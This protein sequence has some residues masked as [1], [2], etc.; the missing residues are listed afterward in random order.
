M[1]KFTKRKPL[2]TK[3]HNDSADYTVQ[4]FIC[5]I[6]GKGISASILIIAAKY[7][8]IL[9]YS[10]HSMLLVFLQALFFKSYYIHLPG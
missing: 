9:N 2:L 3:L 10:H 4:L 6:V 8:D 1:I 5:S 7:A